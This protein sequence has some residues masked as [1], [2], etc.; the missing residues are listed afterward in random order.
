MRS[1]STSEAPTLHQTC[2]IS[3]NLCKQEEFS[4][5]RKVEFN[6][7]TVYLMHGEIPE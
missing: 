3:K 7:L 2:V 6:E 5:A 4:W 1:L